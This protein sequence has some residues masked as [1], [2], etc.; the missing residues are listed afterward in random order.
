MGDESA[1]QTSTIDL[2]PTFKVEFRV[3]DRAQFQAEGRMLFGL[4]KKVEGDN[5]DI[6]RQW[7]G[8]HVYDVRLMHAGIQV[9][10]VMS[11]NGD[12]ALNLMNEAIPRLLFGYVTQEQALNFDRQQFLVLQADNSRV[13][14]FIHLN[15]QPEIQAG[16]HERFK[17][18]S[19][20]LIFYLS[21]ERNRLS[22]K[23]RKWMRREKS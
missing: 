19:D 5:P 20:M 7:S 2:L 6:R 15:Y 23:L 16:K 14:E 22:V 12:D 17:T 3:F 13:G 10:R 9:H 1:L 8:N 4:T 18:L 11:D 21:K